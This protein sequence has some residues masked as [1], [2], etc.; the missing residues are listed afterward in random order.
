MNKRKNLYNVVLVLIIFFCLVLL[1][2]QNS[3]FI[4]GK[5]TEF[6][7]PSNVSVTNYLAIA[8]SENLSEGIIFGDV[9]VLPAVNINASHN[10]DGNNS[11][12]TLFINVSEDGNT[13]VDFCIR[14]N[15]NLTSLVEDIIGLGNETYSNSTYNN[16]THPTLGEDVALTTSYVK[17]GDAIAVGGA[18]YY[19]FWLDVQASQPSGDYNNTL[20]FKGVQTTVVC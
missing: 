16:I 20:S 13:A 1:I 8:F 11:A 12:T 18:N 7:T 2:F 19:R 6:F 5:V 3:Y 14:G 17:S 15:A 10:Y 9:S 4:S